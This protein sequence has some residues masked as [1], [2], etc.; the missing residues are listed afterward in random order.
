MFERCISTSGAQFPDWCDTKLNIPVE[1]NKAYPYLIMKTLPSGV[2]GLVLVSMIVSMMSALASVFNS[3]STIFTLD[4]YKRF[5]NKNASERRLMNVGRLFTIVMIGLSFGWLFAIRA[6][7]SGIFLITQN[8]QTHLAPPLAVVAVLGIFFPRVNGQGAL[9]GISVGF[10]VG[11]G[12]YV[13]SLLVDCS[14]NGSGFGLWISCLHFNHFASILALLTGVVT[15]AVSLFY[16]PPEEYQLKGIISDLQVG[17][18]GD[19]KKDM[20]LVIL[21]LG[22]ILITTLIIIVFR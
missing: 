6:Q 16:P 9:A 1:T 5:V 19:R 7:D 20:A 11:L 22:L 2:V 12:Q 4:I 10:L 14:A 3:A 18:K 15:I 17:T 21:A 13:A 8:V